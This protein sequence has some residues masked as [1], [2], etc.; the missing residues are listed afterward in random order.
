MAGAALATS[1]S[2]YISAGVL[3]F[4]LLRQGKLFSADLKR[5]PSRQE[6]TPLF[7]VYFGIYL[8]LMYTWL[9]FE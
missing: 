5:V 4:K 9:S 3:Y 7:K 6:L 2:Q 1:A 8:F